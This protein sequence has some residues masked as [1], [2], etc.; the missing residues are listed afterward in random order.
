MTHKKTAGGLAHLMFCALVA[1]HLA[2]REGKVSDMQEEDRFLVRWLGVAQEQQRFPP[3]LETDLV[4]LQDKGRLHGELRAYME[5]L[6]SV[7]TGHGDRTPPVTRLVAA[8]AGLSSLG[9]EHSAV[10]RIA[11]SGIG[12]KPV[13][14]SAVPTTN[15][16]KSAVLRAFTPQGEQRWPVEFKVVG[17]DAQVFVRQLAQVQLRAEITRTMP[18]CTWVT[19]LPVDE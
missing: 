4:W 2:I 5:S 14:D 13:G 6:W 16:V 1:L 18:W 9:W 12:K 8:M 11:W 7:S 17:G 15:V 3:G 19:L 10:R